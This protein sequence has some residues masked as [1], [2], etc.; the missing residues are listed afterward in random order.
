MNFEQYSHVMHG[1]STVIFYS[2]HDDILTNDPCAGA[3]VNFKC[4][5]WK[6]ESTGMALELPHLHSTLIDAVCGARHQW[7][8]VHVRFALIRTETG[9][10]HVTGLHSSASCGLVEE[11]KNKNIIREGKRDK[12]ATASRD[13][14][15]K[16]E[17]CGQWIDFWIGV[18]DLKTPKDRKV[19]THENRKN[20]GFDSLDL[21]PLPISFYY[22]LVLWFYHLITFFFFK[23][24][25]LIL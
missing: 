1:K 22:S 25:N 13:W 10:H 24:N 8:C 16:R 23:E 12:D 15:S 9:C 17:S 7:P 11:G 14:E 19:G 21:S 6:L 2:C 20:T 5:S 3:K 18:L 4:W